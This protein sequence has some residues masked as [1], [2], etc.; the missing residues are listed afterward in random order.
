MKVSVVGLGKVGS[1]VAFLLSLKNYITELVLLGRNRE[2]TAGDALDLQ[3]GQLFA[4][5]P[6]KIW[7]G[8]VEDTTG[9]EMI[10]MCASVATPPTMTERLSLT[11]ANVKLMR[12]LLPPLAERSP[13]AKLIMVSNPV[14]ILCYFALKC[15]NY[16]PHQVIGTG[17]LVDSARFRQ[18]IADEVHINLA[19]IRAYILGEHGDSQFLALSSAS[20]G[21]EPLDDTPARRA[22]AQR[23][24]QAG[25]EVFRLKGYTNF[26]IALAAEAI[27]DSIAMHA[28]QTLPVSVLCNG[29]LGHH[30]VCLSLPAVIGRKGI[31]RIMHPRLN[32]EEEALFHRSAQVL[33]DVI[34]RVGDD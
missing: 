4:E 14:D 10:V 23:A 29:F 1:S 21:G 17:T 20:A 28:R 11:D 19:D 8:E 31:E 18:L 13:R 3:H 9:S 30:D 34:A 12:E 32:T 5:S 33:K 2:R 22:M 24:A 26:T 15:T 25:L 6:S 7:A 16:A 27:V